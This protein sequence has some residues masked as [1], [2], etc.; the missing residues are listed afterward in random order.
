MPKTHLG[1]WSVGLIITFLV[2]FGL[3]QIL[4]ISGQEGGET[5]SDNL[6]LAVPAFSMA[7]AGIVAFFV[8]IISIIKNKEQ[9]I[10]V[11]IATAIG[12]LVLMF[13][14]GE[15]LFPH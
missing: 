3:V 2:L 11:F 14:L 12:L 8:G 6:I 15:I 7:I 4:V 10:L 9:S 5:F 13:V 1:R